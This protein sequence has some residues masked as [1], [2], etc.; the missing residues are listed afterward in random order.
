MSIL[1][2]SIKI[3]WILNEDS[4]LVGIELKL[5]IYVSICISSIDIFY[6][7]AKFYLILVRNP[8]YKINVHMD[9]KMMI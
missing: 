5:L 3:P 8:L 2:P 7:L 9:K 6:Y 4:D 1:H